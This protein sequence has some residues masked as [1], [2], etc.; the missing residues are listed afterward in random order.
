MAEQIEGSRFA[1]GRLAL[2]GGAALGL[3]TWGSALVELF[4]YTEHIQ[5]STNIQPNIHN[6]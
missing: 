1:G 6:N 2:V 4:K 3:A 5:I